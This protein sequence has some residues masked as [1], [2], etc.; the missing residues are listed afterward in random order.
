ME[1]SIR[2]IFLGGVSLFMLYSFVSMT[3][4]NSRTKLSVDFQEEARKRG[5]KLLE[6]SAETNQLLR[7]LIATV[8]E[9]R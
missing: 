4:S 9:K 7:E 6:L 8:R 3:R 5:E 1:D 2:W